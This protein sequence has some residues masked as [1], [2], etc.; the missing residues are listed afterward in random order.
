MESFLRR[1]TCLGKSSKRTGDCRTTHKRDSRSAT[2]GER[3]VTLQNS[4]RE[5]RSQRRAT[6]PLPRG[7]ECKKPSVV[8]AGR[9]KGGGRMLFLGKEVSA[10]SAALGAAVVDAGLEKHVTPIQLGA[11]ARNCNCIQLGAR[12]RV[13]NCN[14]IQLGARARVTVTV[15]S[16]VRARVRHGRQPSRLH[17][18]LLTPPPLLAASRAGSRSGC[19]W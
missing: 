2:K 5:A 9:K 13:R 4:K 16:W 10:A 3:D 14:C 1:K 7:S 19:R 18:A 11:R 6:G 12:A 15:Y 8:P 17:P